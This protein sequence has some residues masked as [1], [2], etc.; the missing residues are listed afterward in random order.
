MGGGDVVL[1]VVCSSYLAG[2]EDEI[3]VFFLPPGY[4]QPSS[5]FIFDTDY[6]F[7]DPITPWGFLWS[8]DLWH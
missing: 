2:P 4:F 6:T 1:K 5:E 8:D 3:K 7:P